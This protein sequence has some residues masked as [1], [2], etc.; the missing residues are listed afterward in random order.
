MT[1]NGG[2]T[3]GGEQL[4]MRRNRVVDITFGRVPIALARCSPTP[5]DTEPLV[6]S[7]SACWARASSTREHPQRVF[8]V[9]VYGWFYVQPMNQIGLLLSDF[10]PCWNATGGASRYLKH[11]G[12]DN[13]ERHSGVQNFPFE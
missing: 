11:W 9:L 6:D 13:R 12:A 3:Y 2:E 1:R 5:R 7:W 8:V 4:V 10:V